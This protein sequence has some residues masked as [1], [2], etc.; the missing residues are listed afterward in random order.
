MNSANAIDPALSAVLQTQPAQ[1]VEF[2]VQVFFWDVGIL[3]AVIDR[4]APFY[5]RG[6]KGM[7][8]EN[9]VIAPC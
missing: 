1:R 4:F 3:N 7:L 6:D 9:L 5:V 2:Q 8:F